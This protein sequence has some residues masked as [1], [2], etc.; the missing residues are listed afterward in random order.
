[1]PSADLGN[2][3]PLQNQ[4]WGLKVDVHHPKVPLLCSHPLRDRL[5]PEGLSPAHLSLG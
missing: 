4:R 3:S 1:M 2:H 5:S